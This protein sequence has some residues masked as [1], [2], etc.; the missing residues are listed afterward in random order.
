MNVQYLDEDCVFFKDKKEPVKT[1]LQIYLQRKL[2]Q[3]QKGMPGRY[4]I[5][6]VG[7]TVVTSATF[8]MVRIVSMGE[9][10]LSVLNMVLSC[11]VR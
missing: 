4:T 7:N 8:L 3:D 6:P 2:Q 11:A 10:G 9:E 1:Q 5:H